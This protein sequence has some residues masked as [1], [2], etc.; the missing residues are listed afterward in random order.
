M[1]NMYTNLELAANWTVATGSVYFGTVF[2]DVGFELKRKW[3]TRLIQVVGLA[4]TIDTINNDNWPQTYR[5]SYILEI[6][7]LSL[8]MTTFEVN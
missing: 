7:L 2:N 8:T 1:V 3:E 5:K 4:T 6:P